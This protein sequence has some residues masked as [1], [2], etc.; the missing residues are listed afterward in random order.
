MNIMET[1]DK[2][3]FENYLDNLKLKYQDML[4]SVQPSQER[5]EKRKKMA[6]ELHNK[7][8]N[9]SQPKF[10]FLD[11]LKSL[12]FLWSIPQYKFAYSAISLIVIFTLSFIVFNFQSGNWTFHRTNQLTNINLD[13]NKQ[14][15]T[16]TSIILTLTPDKSVKITNEEIIAKIPIEKKRTFGIA[17]Q[18]VETSL[19]QL[20]NSLQRKFKDSIKINKS[21]NQYASE[22]LRLSKDN[23]LINEQTRVTFDLK[24]NTFIIK[25]Q[26]AELNLDSNSLK[27]I[28]KDK[29]LDKLRKLKL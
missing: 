4:N 16:D 29:F 8:Y 18:N 7:L 28:E 26:S 24:N 23:K 15:V 12:K 14:S 17:E 10:K 11:I 9:S 27:K 21:N 25:M 6:E 5:L 20:A 19:K 13:S 2:N 22:W 1:K 3:N